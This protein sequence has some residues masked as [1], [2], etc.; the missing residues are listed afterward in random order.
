MRWYEPSSNLLGSLK[1][2]GA[3]TETEKEG[4]MAKSEIEDLIGALRK[5]RDLRRST[6]VERLTWNLEKQL[7]EWLKSFQDGKGMGTQ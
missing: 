5:L 6:L 4:D 2:I 1:R 7:S 3:C